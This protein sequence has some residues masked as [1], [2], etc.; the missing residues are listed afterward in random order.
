M[1]E[2]SIYICVNIILFLS[3]KDYY[4]ENSQELYS[5]KQ[6]KFLLLFTEKFQYQIA[7]KGN[8]E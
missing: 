4:V 2:N 6:S 1:Q 8:E 5:L 7:E 3:N